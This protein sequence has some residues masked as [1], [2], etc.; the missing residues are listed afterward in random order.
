MIIKQ[1]FESHVEEINLYFNFLEKIEREEYRLINN[2]DN[3][4]T[5]YVINDELLKVLKAN[6]Y[7][8]LYN[9]IESTI[10]NSI[11]SIFDNISI[12]NLN[13]HDVTEKIKK[14]WLRH[15]Y[16]YDPL[17]VDEKLIY[18]KCYSIVT[19]IFQ[20]ITISMT[21]KIKYGGSLDAKG[22]RDLAAELGITLSSDH[23]SKDMHGEALLQIKKNRN[24]LAHGKKTF[25]EIARDITYSGSTYIN[26]DGLL[27]IQSLGLK[28]LRDFTIEHLEKYIDSIEIFL[29]NKDYKFNAI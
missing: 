19:K 21:D 6:G 23:Y 9:L 3:S 12:D 20:E 24:D 25:S 4:L 18:N 13:F 1:E 8:L 16:K 27:T 26:E 29:S 17:I 15:T 11:V 5:P 14:F 2:F 28:H 22:I 7:I 10:F